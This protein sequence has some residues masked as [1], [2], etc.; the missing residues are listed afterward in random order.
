MLLGAFYMLLIAA[1]LYIASTT[2]DKRA[3]QWNYGIAI[4]MVIVPIIVA[5]F[6]L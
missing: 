1:N 3:K 5:K 6:D 2:N 4:A